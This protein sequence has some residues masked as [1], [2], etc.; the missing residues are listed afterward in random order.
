MMM[1]ERGHYF[2]NKSLFAFTLFAGKTKRNAA[3][4]PALIRKWAQEVFQFD[5]EL[6]Y[7]NYNN[8]REDYWRP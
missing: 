6:N 3:Y 7:D 8:I 4:Q 1:K 5:L 2:N